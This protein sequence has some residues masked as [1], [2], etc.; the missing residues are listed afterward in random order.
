MPELVVPLATYTGWNLYNERSGPANVMATTTGSFIP[1]PRTR[2][3]REKTN[4]P[5]PSVEERYG[6][7]D[8]YLDLVSKSANELVSKGYLIKEDVPRIVQ[9]AGMRWDFV[10]GAAN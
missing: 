4:D 2:A 7:R 6:T 1:F 3:E 9:Q 5:R 10:M 8:H